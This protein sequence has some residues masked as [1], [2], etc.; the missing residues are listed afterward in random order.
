MSE[1]E[2]IQNA[3]LHIIRPQKYQMAFWGLIILIG[4]IAI[5]SAATVMVTG[6]RHQPLMPGIE[7]SSQR[8]LQGM[9]HELDLT[10]DQQ[11]QIEPLIRQHMAKLNE[12]RSKAQPLIMQEFKL[13]H[14]EIAKVLTPEQL[15]LWEERLTRIPEDFRPPMPPQVPGVP[16]RVLPGQPQR[17]WPHQQ[18]GVPAR[19]QNQQQDSQPGSRPMGPPPGAMMDPRQMPDNPPSAGVSDD[20][21][22]QFQPLMDAS[23][24]EQTPAAQQPQAPQQDET[25]PPPPPDDAGGPGPAPQ[26]GAP[27][28]PMGPPPQE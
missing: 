24:Q 18:P 26:D 17:E 25:M 3:T 20:S 4:G 1:K 11:R 28:G 12:I 14:D 9:Q 21:S 2:I 23:A 7:G 27:D 22:A 6:R 10:P 13:M 15:R 19:P 16:S 8:M 5:G